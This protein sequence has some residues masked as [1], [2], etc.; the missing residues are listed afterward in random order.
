MASS[1][2]DILLCSETLVSDIRHVS[3]MLVPGFG[4]PV[5]LCWGKM[6]R[7]RGMAAYVWD[8]YGAFHQPKFEC[9]CCK[10]LIFKVCGVRQNL[11]EFSLYSNPDL[12][13]R[14]FDCMLTS[15]AA[16]QTENIRA[17]FLFVGDLNVIIR[18]SWVLPPQTVMELQHLTLQL[19]PVAISWLSAQPCTWW[20]SWPPDDWCLWP[21]TGC[22]CSSDKQLRSL[23]SVSSHF[24]LSGDS[25]LELVG[26]FSWNIKSTGIQSVVQYRICLGITFGLL[27][28]LSRF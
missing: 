9:G 25:K 20:N 21:S 3:E 11:Y 26:K 18:G 22:W 6:P 2:Y 19:S 28:I 5:S 15:M 23:Q 27:T 14:I 7:A 24:D 4:H 13:D 10:M 12:D 17:S 16:V 8:G 1:Q